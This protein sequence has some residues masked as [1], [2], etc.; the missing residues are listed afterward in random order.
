MSHIVELGT[1]IELVSMDRHFH[2]ISISLYQDDDGDGGIEFTVH[3]YSRR[4]GT[5]ARINVVKTAM[6]VLGGVEPASNRGGRFRFPCGHNH[7][8]AV[9]RL[10]IDS[11][12]VAPGD[13]LEPRLLS[14]F[15]KKMDLTLFA[16]GE[17][18]GRYRL[19]ADTEG[20]DADRRIDGITRGLTKLAELEAL[21]TGLAAFPCGRPH[22]ELVGLL[23]GRALNVRAAMREAEA[24]A[25]RGMLAAPS[26]QQ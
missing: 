1:R 4:E 5:A 18:D 20:P 6:Q 8:R 11:C 21:D 23:L 17:G 25:A 14:V 15:D 26:Q 2:D 10:F 22:D 19:S 13:A 3:S 12:K 9:Q 16:T 7:R 24:A